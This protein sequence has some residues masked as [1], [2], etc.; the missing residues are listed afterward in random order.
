MLVDVVH[1]PGMHTRSGDPPPNTA[2]PPLRHASV[3]TTHVTAVVAAGTVKNRASVEA[4]GI[5]ARA[6]KP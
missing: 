6:Q 2:V 1:Y 5:F 4:A 3:L